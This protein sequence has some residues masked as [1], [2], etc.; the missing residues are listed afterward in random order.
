MPTFVNKKK[1]LE[2][3]KNVKNMKNV[4]K[5]FLNVKKTFLHL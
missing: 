3:K 1:L 2:N 4:N 5:I